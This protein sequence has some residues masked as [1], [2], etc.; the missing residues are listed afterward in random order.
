MEKREELI[1]QECDIYF[2]CAIDQGNHDKIFHE[3]FLP[4]KDEIDDD[5]MNEH[6]WDALTDADSSI[7]LN[8]EKS[9]Q[10]KRDLEV[11][12]ELSRQNVQVQTVHCKQELESKED[13]EI[14][15]DLREI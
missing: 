11:Q 12:T 14:N 2:N 7:K 9:L 15:N 3:D 13:K 8:I 4:I 1:C 5:N 10:L 6:D